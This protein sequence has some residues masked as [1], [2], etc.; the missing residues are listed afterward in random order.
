MNRFSLTSTV[1][2]L[3]L[4]TPTLAAQQPALPDLPPPG[5]SAVDRLADVVNPPPLDEKA[6]QKIVNDTLRD[7]DARQKAADEAKKTAAAD[8]GHEV[9][10]DLKLNAA[11]NNGLWFSTPDKDWNIHFGG[12][13]TFQ[14]SFFAQPLNLRGTPPGNGGIPAS[15]PGAGIGTLDD[16]MFFRRVRLRSDGTAYETFEYIAEID[17]EQLNLMTFDHLWLGIRDDYYGSVRL[18][19]VK[20]PMGMEMVG[21]DYHLTFIERSPLFDAFL[22]LFAPGLYYQNS[23]LDQNVL[24]Q[25]MFHRVQPLQFFAN[26]FGNGN[27]ASTSRLIVTPWYEGDGAGVLAVGGSYQYRTGDLGR[28]LQP[29]G[30]GSTFGDTQNVAR[31]RS[32]INIRDATGIGNI[33]FLG[34]NSNRAVDTGF[35]LTDGVHTVVP[36]FL[37]NMGPFSIQADAAFTFVEDARTL[38]GGGGLQPLQNVGTAMFWGGYVEASYLLTGETRGYDRRNGTYDRVRVREPFFLARGEDGR[39]RFGTGAW[40]VAYRYSFLDLND[41]GINGGQLIQHEVAL[42]WYMNDNAKLQFVYLNADRL[43]PTP[44]QSGIVNGFAVLAQWYF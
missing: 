6:V 15:G 39:T 44:A 30:T 32:R 26:D 1:A 43:V 24:F 35:M 37:M 31:F 7:R 10:S 28:T 29:G 38:Y 22:T 9:G 34:A 41:S 21:S 19:Q 14:S 20:V 40:Q 16:G 4:A 12:R 36:E 17:F 2:A 18:G 25:T 42:N 13:F 23:F 8:A 3:L 5:P 27:Y 11:W 33:N